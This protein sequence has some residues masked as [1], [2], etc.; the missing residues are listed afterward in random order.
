MHLSPD[1]AQPDHAE[2]H[3]DLSTGYRPRHARAAAGLCHRLP[4]FDEAPCSPG[5]GRSDQASGRTQHHRPFCRSRQG[6][7]SQSYPRLQI[8][9]LC[10]MR[11][12]DWAGAR[13]RRGHS[14]GRLGIVALT[15]D[16]GVAAI[17]PPRGTSPVACWSLRTHRA[18]Q[19]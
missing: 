18:S 12:A 11:R 4:L 7:D 13:D 8:C 16:A 5:Y 9:W 19:A 15:R 1:T 10:G 6:E 3:D 17:H 14:G 2:V